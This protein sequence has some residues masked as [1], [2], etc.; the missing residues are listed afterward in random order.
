M[1]WLGEDEFAKADRERQMPEFVVTVGEGGVG[2]SQRNRRRDEQYDPASSFN[3]Q[4]ALYCSDSPLGDD[5]CTRW[6]I[7]P[8]LT[9]HRCTGSS[10]A[11]RPALNLSLHDAEKPSRNSTLPAARKQPSTRVGAIL[12]QTTFAKELERK[13]NLNRECLA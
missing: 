6:G 5:L 9:L 11:A 10:A 7:G 13:H 2:P 4:E 3:M 1:Q 12:G 8:N